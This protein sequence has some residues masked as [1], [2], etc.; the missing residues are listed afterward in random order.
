MPPHRSAPVFFIDLKAKHL[1]FSKS[2]PKVPLDIVLNIRSNE[3]VAP[4]HVEGGGLVHLGDAI[5]AR[6]RPY[7]HGYGGQPICR[8]ELEGVKDRAL[9]RDPFAFPNELEQR[10]NR[11]RRNVTFVVHVKYPLLACVNSNSPAV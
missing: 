5:I 7:R 11:L 1:V 2:R 4:V 9:R 6:K 3:Q 8:L 10:E